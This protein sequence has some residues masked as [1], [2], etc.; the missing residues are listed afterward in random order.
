MFVVV[1]IVQLLGCSQLFATP[2]TAALQASQKLVFIEL[3]CVQ[4]I[5]FD[6]LQSSHFINP[7]NSFAS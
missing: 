7:Y 3:D 4:G 6:A 2:W 5:V 1:V